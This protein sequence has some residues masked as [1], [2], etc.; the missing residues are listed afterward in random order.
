MVASAEDVAQPIV[1]GRERFE[2]NKS[3]KEKLRIIL[4]KSIYQ[5]SFV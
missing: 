5:A 1:G 3:H 2:L 4:L